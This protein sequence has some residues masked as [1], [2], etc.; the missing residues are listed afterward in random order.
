MSKLRK[1]HI[2]TVFEGEDFDALEKLRHHYGILN[3][4]GAVKEAV[5]R[6]AEAIKGSNKIRD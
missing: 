3:Y 1:V 2:N 4:V 5:K 6:C